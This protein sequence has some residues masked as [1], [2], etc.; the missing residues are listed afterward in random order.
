[1]RAEGSSGSYVEEQSFR[2]ERV[3]AAAPAGHSSRPPARRP[4]APVACRRPTAVAALPIR[5]TAASATTPCQVSFGAI[6]SPVGIGLMVYGFGAFFNLLPG[7]DVSSLLLIYG[8]PITVG[9]AVFVG[10][11]LG[12]LLLFIGPAAGRQCV[13]AAACCCSSAARPSWSVAFFAALLFK[14]AVPAHLS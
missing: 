5:P 8:F 14:P 6:L 3:G 13:S 12:H 9:A 1:M 11:M 2:I 7:G 4:E 10:T